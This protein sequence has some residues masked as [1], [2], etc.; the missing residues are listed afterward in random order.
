MCHRVD[1]EEVMEVPSREYG[2]G[3]LCAIVWVQKS[4]W[5]HRVDAEE[6]LDLQLRRFGGGRGCA[7]AWMRRRAWIYSREDVEEDLD[8]Q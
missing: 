3:C 7:L 1:V 5:D 4:S 2:G 8:L 6:A